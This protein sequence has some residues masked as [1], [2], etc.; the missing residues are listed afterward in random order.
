MQSETVFRAIGDPTRRQ[1]IGMLTTSDLSVNEIAA[2]FEMTRPAVAKHLGV[3]RK[4][5]LITVTARGRERIHTLHPEA[6]KPIADW[7][8]L[9][10]QFWD[11]KLEDLKLAVEADDE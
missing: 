3:L 11:D 1:I 6:L 5:G 8:G 2:H 7:L 9:F 10:S 4:G